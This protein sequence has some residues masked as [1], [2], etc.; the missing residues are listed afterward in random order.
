MTAVAA[1]DV[2]AIVYVEPFGRLWRK[3]IFG[4]L[5]DDWQAIDDHAFANQFV[6][7]AMNRRRRKPVP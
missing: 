1:D 7:P 5:H 3:N 4:R 2:P 6:A